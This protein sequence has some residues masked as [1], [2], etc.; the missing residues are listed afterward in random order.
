MKTI[1]TLAVASLFTLPLQAQIMENFSFTP[2]LSVPDGNAVGVYDTQVVTSTQTSISSLT[3]TLNMTGDYNGDL[4]VY[5]QHGSGFSV[6]LNRPGRDNGSF[7]GYGDSGFDITLSGS[8]A[9]DIHTYRT[10][11]TPSPGLKLTGSWQPD[12]RDVNP[13]TVLSGSPRTAGL[14]LFQ[15]LDPNGQWTLFAADLSNGGTSEITSWGLQITAVPEPQS[16]A[17]VVGGVLLGFG[18]LRR[19]RN[20]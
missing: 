12:G 15:G 13:S 20:V 6:L 9:N 19:K 8:A 2:N 3:V 11:V 1:K 17:L 16:I 4:Y 5:L 18:L 7:L 14:D 10:S